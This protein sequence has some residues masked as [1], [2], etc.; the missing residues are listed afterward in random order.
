[1]AKL[2][3]CQGCGKD[4]SHRRGPA[5]WCEDCAVEQRREKQPGYMAAF[6]EQHPDYW[7]NWQRNLRRS[8]KRCASHRP[9][10]TAAAR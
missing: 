4:I 2:S 1:M 3:N 8:A 5:V 10:L 6:R 9:A 7:R